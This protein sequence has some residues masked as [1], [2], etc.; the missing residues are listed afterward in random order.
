MESLQDQID[1]QLAAPVRQLVDSEA[2]RRRF[3]VILD[4]L[5]PG[6]AIDF[7]AGASASALV[8][9]ETGVAGISASLSV[10]MEKG[11]SLGRD[12]GGAFEL[13][14]RGDFKG[15]FGGSASVLSGAVEAS[16][17]LSANASQCL[18]L[19]FKSKDDA[20]AFLQKLSDGAFSPEDLLEHCQNVKTEG[21]VSAGAAATVKAQLGEVKVFD[22]FPIGTQVVSAGFEASGNLARKT[23]TDASAQTVSTTTAV[24]GRL[25]VTLNVAK[26]EEEEDDEDDGGIG[27]GDETPDFGASDAMEAAGVQGVEVGDGGPLAIFGKNVVV[28]AGA[29]KED[30]GFK[31][32]AS[33]MAARSST[34]TRSTRG[35]DRGRLA[36]ASQDISLEFAG[37]YAESQLASYAD[38]NLNLSPSVIES[39]RGD[40]QANG[41]PFTLEVS[42]SLKPEVAERCRHLEATPG[43]NK[44]VKALLRDESNYETSAVKLVFQG[45]QE[46]E[47]HGVTINTGLVRFEARQ[48]AKAAETISVEYQADLSAEG[49]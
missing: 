13:A 33:V 15:G 9:V 26:A 16:L 5:D 3:S 1:S 34:V 43:S 35:D 44:E 24:R 8:G 7:S 32:E 30:G 29:S 2:N 39:M 38:K 10:A 18:K 19:T 21:A 4:H 12:A 42:R 31:L 47:S 23:E 25:A 22:N 37:R 28:A 45:R 48:D 46:S 17:G 49:L 40:V 14:I 41:T 27:L 11:I 20:A 36:G 6:A